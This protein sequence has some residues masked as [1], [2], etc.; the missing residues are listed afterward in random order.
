MRVWDADGGKKFRESFLDSFD[1]ISAAKWGIMLTKNVG[2]A[3]KA[4]R[5]VVSLGLAVR[6]AWDEYLRRLQNG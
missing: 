3:D 2:T 6:A 1:R 5:V 4:V